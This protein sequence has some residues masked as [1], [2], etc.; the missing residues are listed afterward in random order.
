M[1]IIV[2]QTALSKDT[3]LTPVGVKTVQAVLR[4]QKAIRP[5][6]Q[7]TRDRTGHGSGMHNATVIAVNTPVGGR[8]AHGPVVVAGVLDDNTQHRQTGQRSKGLAQ[9]VVSGTGGRNTE[10]GD[11]NG[12][13]GHSGDKAVGE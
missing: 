9:I 7:R 8:M 11:G 10:T 2:L 6:R 4:Q 5:T 12:S 13:S 1:A 3:G